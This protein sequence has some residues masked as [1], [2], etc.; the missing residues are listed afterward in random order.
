ML[1]LAAKQ[2]ATA[3]SEIVAMD[4]TKKDAVYSLGLALEEMGKKSEALEEFKKIYE[5]DSRYRDVAER[6][7]SAYQQSPE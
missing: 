1:D 3:A 7:E 6:V 4:A 2:Y 5:I